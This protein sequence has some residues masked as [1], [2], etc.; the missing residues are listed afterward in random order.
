MRLEDL[1]SL[2][3]S[4]IN[5]SNY[6]WDHVYELSSQLEMLCKSNPGLINEF[7]AYL[8]GLVA[9]DR[10]N[11]KIENLLG[12]IS[13][14]KED[15]SNAIVYYETAIAKG[16]ELA[17]GNRAHMH[18]E[19]IGGPVNMPEA[20]RLYDLAIAKGNELALVKRAHLHL[21][22]IGGPVNIPEAIRLLN[23]AISK[24][25][26]AAM[27]NRAYMYESGIGGP[28]NIPEAIRLYDQAIEEK[29][30]PA[31]CERA[32]MY[33][34]GVG[35]PKNIEK[36]TSLLIAAF[37]DKSSG[38][39]NKREILSALKA[40]AEK[41]NNLN[42]KLVLFIIYSQ[43]NNPSDLEKAKKLCNSSAE[44][45]N[46]LLGI[47]I[48]QLTSNNSKFPS[49]SPESIEFLKG[50]VDP[51]LHPLFK[52]EEIVGREALLA[53]KLEEATAILLSLPI[54]H[55]S[56]SEHL[57]D[58]IML[59]LN[60]VESEQKALVLAYL[61]RGIRYF[62]ESSELDKLHRS[63]VLQLT[64]QAPDISAETE[65]S[66]KQRHKEALAREIEL[67][68]LEVKPAISALETFIMMKKDE[69][70]RAWFASSRIE[71]ELTFA[72]KLLEKLR[73][74]IHPYVV[75]QEHKNELENFA[76]LKSI[77][78]KQC[79]L[80]PSALDSSPS[81]PPATTA[82]AAASARSS[83][84]SFNPVAAPG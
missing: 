78:I 68:K 21:E 10:D 22:G 46:A 1:I 17:M 63:L 14:E 62:P 25:N 26:P 15:F 54:E 79:H 82:F 37:L 52:L 66:R 74:G 45:M 41:E 84:Q 50:L 13:K 69:V 71:Q 32:L 48:Q 16:N 18:L 4:I 55:F 67:C 2:A 30:T 58:F 53:G 29:F 20:I 49:I 43:T 75:Y 27:Y 5:N 38:N 33:A 42:A 56:N 70:S 83:T 31:M 73:M 6:S 36:A 11:G 7:E 65:E 8:K 12:F 39:L 34:K 61:D 76:L 24:R 44:F 9:T 77:M 35:G 28:V 60:S 47:Y 23:L 51:K 80:D 40:I 72:Q 64:G 57:I 19:G 3:D 81:H 59:L